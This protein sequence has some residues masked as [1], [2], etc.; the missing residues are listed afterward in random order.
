[1]LSR[2]DVDI[3]GGHAHTSGDKDQILDRRLKTHPDLKQASGAGLRIDEWFYIY[4]WGVSHVHL[5]GRIDTSSRQPHQ[6]WYQRIG[7][8]PVEQGQY[9]LRPHWKED[10]VRSTRNAL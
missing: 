7:E 3:V 8:M 10:Y 6:E 1:M 5:S 9:F 2:C 4:R